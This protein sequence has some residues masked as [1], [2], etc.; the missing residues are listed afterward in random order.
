MIFYTEGEKI[1]R[2]KT[3]KEV[4]KHCGEKYGRRKP[5]VLL[6]YFVGRCNICSNDALVTE[7]NNFGGAK[8]KEVRPSFNNE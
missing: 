6:P 5:P 3:A 4:C 2:S 7:L 8:D 1:E